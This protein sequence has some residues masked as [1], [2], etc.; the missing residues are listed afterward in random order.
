MAPL[1]E[2]IITGLEI[3]V[4]LA[5]ETKKGSFEARIN[6]GRFCIHASSSEISVSLR[7]RFKIKLQEDARQKYRTKLVPNFV[8]KQGAP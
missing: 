4:D 2:D 7:F 6:N 3:S 8:R 1:A 5:G